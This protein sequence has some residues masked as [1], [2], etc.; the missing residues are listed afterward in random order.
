MKKFIVVITVILF[1]VM[2][3][4]Q[5][6]I[7]VGLG[8]DVA[9]PM[10]DFADVVKIGHSWT[11]FGEYPINPK[12]SIQLI[13]GYTIYAANT[14]EIGYQGKVIT[15]DLKSIP[16]KGAVKYFIYD[17]FYLIGELGVNLI[18]VTAN[19]QDAYGI[20]T[21]ESTDFQAKFAMGAGIGTSFKLSE[22]SLINITSKYLYVN[23]GDSKIDFSHILLGA[24]LV[25]HFDI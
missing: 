10:G 7:S 25:V 16:I 22:Q 15:F 5:D 8:Y 19:F 2:S 9:F 12:Y 17:E 18:K 20:T 3:Y 21:T 23:G 14:G 24:S 6:R 4:S 1:S 13:T 11:L